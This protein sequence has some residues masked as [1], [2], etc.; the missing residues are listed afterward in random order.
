[1]GTPKDAL[2]IAEEL[3]DRE[4]VDM[5]SGCMFANVCLALGDYAQHKQFPIM[6]W[7]GTYEDET[8]R[9]SDYAFSLLAATVPPRAAAEYVG[10]NAPNKWLSMG[11]NYAYG[12]RTVQVFSEQLLKENPSVSWGDTFWFPLGKLDPQSLVSALQVKKPQAFMSAGFGPDAVAFMREYKKRPTEGMSPIVSI[13]TGTP[14]FMHT[15]GAEL[16]NGWIMTGYPSTDIPT[17]EHKAFADK[18]RKK[19]NEDPSWMALNGYIAYK[20]IFAGLEHAKSLSPQD[21]ASA[22]EGIE[23][24]SPVGKL[25]MR[26]ADHLSTYGTWVGKSTVVNGQP[27]LIDWKYY[28]AESLLIDEGS[29]KHQ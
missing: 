10:A 25:R 16:P 17:P 26:S 29:V 6:R 3:V 8:K 5:L 14:E 21:I 2:R 27:K 23:I 11:P 22:L 28:P 19:Y 13:E 12:H 24:D 20:F 18:F 9:E 15:I 4:K 1:M 7:F